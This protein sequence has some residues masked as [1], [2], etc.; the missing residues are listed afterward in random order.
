MGA[1]LIRLT[2]L[3]KERFIPRGHGKQEKTP[4]LYIIIF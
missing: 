3:F 1:F 2:K 4:K